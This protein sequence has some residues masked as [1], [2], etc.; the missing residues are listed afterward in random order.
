LYLHGFRSSPLSAKA[1]LLAERM[2]AIGLGDRFWCRHLPVSPR[3]AI[4][5]IEEAIAR[6]PVV[7]TLVGSSLGG[8]YATYL[9]EK[10]GLRA[11][12]INP[13]VVAHLSLA[14]YVG[15]QTNSY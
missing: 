8:Y 11:V 1:R 14:Q 12:L 4:E 13:A 9:A 3:R 5:E 7:P 15:P 10:H 6:S 2:A